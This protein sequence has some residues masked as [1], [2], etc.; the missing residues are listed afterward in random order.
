MCLFVR[1]GHPVV[2]ATTSSRS[3]A[4][5]LQRRHLPC[6][7]GCRWTPTCCWRPD[8]ATLAGVAALI[9]VSTIAVTLKPAVRAARVD[10][11]RVLR[12]E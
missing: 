8:P 2:A 10:L 5:E 6:Q 12:E 4:C 11:V 1:T 9:L 7:D 3:S